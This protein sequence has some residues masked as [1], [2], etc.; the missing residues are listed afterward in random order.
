MLTI[1]ETPVVLDCLE[2]VLL[3]CRFI[4]ALH[5]FLQPIEHLNATHPVLK[6]QVFCFPFKPILIRCRACGND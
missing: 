6:I 2:P 5:S 4:K 1:L 3:D